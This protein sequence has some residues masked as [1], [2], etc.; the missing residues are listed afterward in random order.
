MNFPLILYTVNYDLGD[1][2]TL[3]LSPELLLQIMGLF[4]LVLVLYIRLLLLMNMIKSSLETIHI[5]FLISAGILAI[6]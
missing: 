1:W 5:H 2:K 4:I 6:E 3:L